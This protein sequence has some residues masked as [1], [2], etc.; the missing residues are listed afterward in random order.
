M[1]EPVAGD[2]LLQ[3]E[4]RGRWLRFRE[5]R[6]VIAAH[7][8][9]DVVPA[10]EEIEERVETDGLHAAGFIDYEAAPGFDAALRVAAQPVAATARRPAAS[11]P[12]A[13]GAL[14]LVRFALHDPPEEFDLLPEARGASRAP[15]EWTPS[16]TREAYDEAIARVREHIAR[17]ETYQVNFTMRLRAPYAGHPWAWFLQLA[18][19]QQ[20][21]HAAYLDLGDRVILSAS[22][23]LFF[24]L[25]RGRVIARPMKGTA[26][27][28]PEFDADRDEAAR[29]A[30]C[31]KNRAENLMIVDMMRN[32]LGRIA[33]TGSVRVPRLFEVERYPT[34]WQMTSTVEARTERPVTEILRA[35]FPPASVTGA[36]KTSTMRII[37]ALEGEARGVYTGAIGF[38]APG[39]SAEFN[40]AIRTVT[41]D[42][43][44]GV[45]EF[46]VGGGIVWDSC[47]DAEFEECRVKARVLAASRPRFA[48]LETLSWTPE[49]GYHLLE[50]HLR[51]MVN[52]A[53]YFGYPD[54]PVPLRRE[55]AA[56]AARMPPAP[57]RVRLT[58]DE[59]GVPHAEDEPLAGPPAP[60]PEAAAARA[61][62]VGVAAAAVDSGDPFLHHK[63]THREVY[64]RALASR[65]DA[66]DVILW[67]ERGEI[68]ETTTANLVIE[69][70][71]LWLTPP[72]SSGLLAGTGRAALLAEARIRESVIPLDA[73]GRASGIWLV[74]SV[75]G[76]RRAEL[77]AAPA[78]NAC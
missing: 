34:L 1:H 56:L 58:L 19:A 15:S 51:R 33:A 44:S 69:L 59:A 24:W 3:S 68:T 55:L 75:R 16:V 36:P 57:R 76:W 38:M 8:P 31:P 29:L 64:A 17:G 22:P 40:V 60:T 23:E 12:A 42:R 47:A 28:A 49:E 18:R 67:N 78:P 13:S 70:E 5:P 35:L 50:A 20:A 46:G 77:R 32:D 21:G 53:R 45:A 48:L 61:I 9:E 39:R 74:N 52:S 25:D 30:R 37:A 2:A 26:P 27:R 54:D 66:E 65:P 73:L 7:R 10:L 43:R 41:L 71:G 11:G 72:L 62:T 4:T 6:L 63:T 14:P